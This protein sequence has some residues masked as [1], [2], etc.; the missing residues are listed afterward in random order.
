MIEGQAD[1][2]LQYR[3]LGTCAGVLG[4]VVTCEGFSALS[5]SANFVALA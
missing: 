2:W 5:R 4:E 1:G 3:R